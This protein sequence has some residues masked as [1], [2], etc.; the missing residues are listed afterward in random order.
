MSAGVV[1]GDSGS[2][3]GHRPRCWVAG[4][5]IVVVVGLLGVKWCVVVVVRPR[6]GHHVQCE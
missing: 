2:P 4:V 6:V 5:G 1:V 3:V